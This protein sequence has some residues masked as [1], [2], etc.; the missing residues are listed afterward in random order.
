[1][2]NLRQTLP[3]LDRLIAFE[4]AA[5]LRSFTRA[6]AELNLTQSAISHSVKMLE[7]D[8]GV[9]L[10]RRE[11]RSV[12]LTGEGRTLLNSVTQALNH[13]GAASRGLR[14]TRPEP[15]RLYADVA[16]AQ[17][18]LLPRLA[19]LQAALPG[20]LVDLIVSDSPSDALSADIAILQGDGVWP[21]RVSQ[22]L[23]AEEIVPVCAPAYLDRFGPIDSVGALA[24]A[25]LI[26][27][28]YDAWAWANWSIWLTEMGVPHA[29]LNRVLQSNLY[30][31]TMQLALDGAGI[32]LAWRR[33]VEDD[34][35]AGRLVVPVAAQLTMRTGYHLVC[36]PGQVQQPA[37]EGTK[38][39]L[40]RELAEQRMAVLP[41]RGNP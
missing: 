3:R 41:G 27:L 11:H 35:L 13:L 12:H 26:D 28:K 6:A 17:Y 15:L 34:L 19:R 1:M 5:R 38:A 10:F 24:S 7:A 37:Y 30:A 18:W 20:V 21:D 33:L 32:A 4:A 9:A 25:E 31:A 2:S 14:A 39:W 29:D 22:H 16:M 8:L 40:L 36:R 23:F